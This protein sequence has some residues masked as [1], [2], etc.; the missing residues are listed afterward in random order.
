MRME[1]NRLHTKIIC[2]LGPAVNDEI[3]DELIEAGMDVVR[4]NFSHGDQDIHHENIKRVQRA[5]KNANKPIGIMLDTKGPEIRLEKIISNQVML[6]K[7]QLF[8]LHTTPVEGDD[9]HASITYSG[10]T[11]DVQVGNRILIDDGLVGMVITDVT[12]ETIVCKVEN[13]GMI[14]S[15]KGVNVPDVSLG[16]PYLSEKDRS[17]ILFGVKAGVDFIA[18]SF[19]RCAEDILEVRKVCSEVEEGNVSIIAKIENMQGV[20]NIDEIL[21]VSEGIMVARGDLGVEIPLEKVPVIQKKLIH[22]AYT[23]G[24]RVITATQ[25]LDSM[26]KNPRPTRAEATDIANAIYDGTSAI[27]LSG[28]TAAGLY[29]VESLKTMVRIAK[30][31]EADINYDKRFRHRDVEEHIDVTNAISHATCTTALDLKAAAIITVTKSGRTAMMISK[32]RPSCPIITCTTSEKVCRQL[33]LSWGVIPL[34]IEEE[35]YTDDLLKRAVEAGEQAGLV[36]QGEVVVMT[37]G[38]PMGIS[39][40]TNLLKV[41]VVGDVL[42]TGKGIT[43]KRCHGVICVA[44]NIEEAIEEFQDGN[45]LVVP[46]TDHRLITQIRKASG[47]IIEDP[48]PNGHGAIAGMSLNIPVIIGAENA[49]QILKS[50]TPISL[51]AE[52]GVVYNDCRQ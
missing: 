36:K 10:L 39:G 47:L 27:M 52:H 31:A 13:D 30:E 28:E 40:T 19:T 24:K 34:V 8:T 42:V 15:N 25:M 21:R 3:L 2:T 35:T 48:N 6:K 49:T 12:E 23:S 32:F 37:A 22:K 44:K 26:M 16:M 14:A 20:N 38:V 1:T 51:D 11:N 5:R 41:H 4:L 46:Q 33:N 29:P 18:A 45:I 50:G 9:K 17:D 7:G 43:N